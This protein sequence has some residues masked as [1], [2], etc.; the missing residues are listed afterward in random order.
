MKIPDVFKVMASRVGNKTMIKKILDNIPKE[1][2]EGYELADILHN[3]K[4]IIVI[5]RSG[6]RLVL[7]KKGKTAQVKSK[8]KKAKKSKKKE[9]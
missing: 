4:G 3:R 8:K 2:S 5:N 1:E 9:K 6:E 7:L